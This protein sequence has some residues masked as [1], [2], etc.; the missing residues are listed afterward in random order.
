M[1]LIRSLMNEGR[2]FQNRTLFPFYDICN[3]DDSPLEEIDR[4]IKC[5]KKLD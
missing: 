2:H 4:N 3:S 5:D 1:P